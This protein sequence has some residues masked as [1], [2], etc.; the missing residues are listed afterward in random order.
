MALNDGIIGRLA[1]GRHEGRLEL[2]VE[3]LAARAGSNRVIEPPISRTT[4]ELRATWVV[5]PAT[6]GE[7]G[8]AVRSNAIR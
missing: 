6:V 3:V 2:V 5:E 7:G 4:R 8:V 1:D